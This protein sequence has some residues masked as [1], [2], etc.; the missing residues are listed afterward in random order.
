MID[1]ARRELERVRREGLD[2]F[3]DTL[4]L[5]SL[6]YLADAGRAVDDTATA[7]LVYPELLRSPGR[8]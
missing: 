6:T 3:R 7:A 8:T 2:R 1:E 4:W 5:A